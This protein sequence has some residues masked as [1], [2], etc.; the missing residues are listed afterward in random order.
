[1]KKIPFCRIWKTAQLRN[2]LK[3]L[4][5]SIENKTDVDDAFIVKGIGFISLKYGKA[6]DPSKQFKT[7]FGISHI[8]EKRN[9]EQKGT[10][11]K[12]AEKLIEVLVYGKITKMVPQKQTIHLEKDGYEAV[13]SLDWSGEKMTWL[14]TGYKIK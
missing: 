12:I 7:G 2:G 6:G 11:L 8:V 1:M 14:I 4:K 5:Y 9:A 13:V 3:A 10:G